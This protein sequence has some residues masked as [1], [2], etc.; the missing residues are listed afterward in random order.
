MLH[1]GATQM[2]AEGVGI[3]DKALDMVEADISALL[4]GGA[5][6]VRDISSNT[7]LAL[8]A[9]YGLT[10]K[11]Q[12][13]I[14]S[15]SNLK[16]PDLLG[17]TPLMNAVLKRQLESADA[18]LEASANIN[19]RCNAGRTA[20][21]Y[22]VTTGTRTLARHLSSAGVDHSAK[23]RDDG[24][25][26]LCL[27]AAL[28]ME[29]TVE[30]LAGLAT[31]IAAA[32]DSTADPAA[33]W[34]SGTGDRTGP[35]VPVVD[36]ADHTGMTPLIYAAIAGSV[37]MIEALLAVRANPSAIDRNGASALWH[38]VANL[39]LLAV[40]ALLA[41][42]A[43][44]NI[45]GDYSP[46][47]EGARNGSQS[48]VATL[49][50]AAVQERSRAAAAAAAAKVEDRR[51]AAGAAVRAAFA[52]GAAAELQLLRHSSLENPHIF[53][54]SDGGGDGGG[55]QADMSIRWIEFEALKEAQARGHQSMVQVLAADLLAYNLTQ[56]ITEDGVWVV[57]P[58][59]HSR[60]ATHTPVSPR[61]WSVSP[62]VHVAAQQALPVQSV[63]STAWCKGSRVTF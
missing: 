16:T 7:A 51:N 45:C 37:L 31:K 42:G 32:S 21:H 52:A 53:S 8:A 10:V 46:L 28:R 24:A 14:A 3:H 35:V 63:T 43:C 61:W 5:N 57:N 25:T 15:G 40:T 13:L 6:N 27:A 26:A 38:A 20:L 44:V 60:L 59:L 30:L 50:A 34:S 55:A 11:V 58:S 56:A 22:A 2:G 9:T 23:A 41:A 18:Q 62:R 47:L 4:A 54:N 12:Q 1:N 49:L 29:P 33:G 39:H 17:R 19:A 48:M 36:L